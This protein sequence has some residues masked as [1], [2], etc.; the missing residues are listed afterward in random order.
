MFDRLHA[1][2]RMAEKLTVGFAIGTLGGLMVVAGV[3][4]IEH[5]SA[6]GLKSSDFATLVAGVLGAVVGGLIS[7][8][9][10]KQTGEQMLLR[11]QQQRDVD[12]H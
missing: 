10:S 12:F 3:A 4:I 7:Y 2:A 11:D 6:E 1:L 5:V 9:I 8:F